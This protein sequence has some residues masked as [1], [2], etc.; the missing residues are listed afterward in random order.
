MG[1]GGAATGVCRQ[2]SEDARNP[3]KK[4]DPKDSLFSQKYARG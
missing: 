1:A 4:T 2:E 3:D